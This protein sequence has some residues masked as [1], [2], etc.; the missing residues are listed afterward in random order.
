VDDFKN[1]L[2]KGF[3]NYLFTIRGLSQRSIENYL[4]DVKSFLPVLTEHHSLYLP[5]DKDTL[6]HSFHKFLSRISKKQK[7]TTIERKRQG[8]KAFA[9]FLKRKGFLNA[10]P[11]SIFKSGKVESRL[12][13]YLSPSEVGRFLDLLKNSTDPFEIRE[14]A[15]LEMIYGCG[16]RL[17]EAIELKLPDIDFKRRHVIV[18]GKGGKT[19]WVPCTASTLS[20]IMRYITVRENLAAKDCLWIFVNRFGG[21]IS[22]RY[23]EMRT[24]ELGLKYLGRNDLHPHLFRHAFATHLLEGGIDLRLLKDLLGHES[25]TT[26]QRYTKVTLKRLFKVYASAHPR[27]SKYS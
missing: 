26:T 15:F 10:V 18:K 25:L 1:T 22:G 7:R 9:A 13:P 6:V 3:S 17:S 2:L 23:L 20:A 19:R 12:P 14:A 5:L 21:K 11:E 8:I 24:A 4:R 27:A 16:L